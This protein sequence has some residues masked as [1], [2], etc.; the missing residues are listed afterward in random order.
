MLVYSWF[1]K[2]LPRSVLSYL[3]RRRFHSFLA[4]LTQTTWQFHINPYQFEGTVY[5]PFV[6]STT[7]K[8]TAIRQFTEAM[9]GISN[10]LFRR[11]LYAFTVQE[12]KE[13]WVD[14]AYWHILFAGVLAVIMVLWRPTN[15]NQRYAFT[16][17]LDNAEDDDGE[18]PASMGKWKSSPFY[19]RYLQAWARQNENSPVSNVLSMSC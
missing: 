10:W 18:W 11:L 6:G 8:Q 9:A 16:P 3:T 15:N 13:V 7:D 5:S 14:E 4:F 2:R 17:L 19:L 12:W 1:W